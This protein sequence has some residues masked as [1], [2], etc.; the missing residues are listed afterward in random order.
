MPGPGRNEP[1]PCGSGR[2]TKRCCGEQRGPSGDQLAR[3][4]LAAL[5]RAAIDDLVHLSDRSLDRLD[6]DLFDL[7]GVDLSL[8][9]KL[10]VFVGPDRR[11]LEKAMADPADDGS[12]EAVKAVRR[13]LDTPHQRLR[14]AEALIA[15]RDQGRIGRSEAAYGIYDLSRGGGR[16]IT[17]SVIHAL[18]TYVGGDPTP[19]GLL[20]AA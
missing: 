17:A 7:P 5:G 8:H 3:A 2:K 9:V 16:L 20:V 10:P 18:A 19:A 15:L 12:W 13:Q 1:C 6:D 14:L 4:R 11:A